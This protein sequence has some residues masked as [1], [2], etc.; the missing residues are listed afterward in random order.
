MS[1]EF[2]DRCLY[3]TDDGRRTSGSTDHRLR[4]AYVLVA[5][6]RIILRFASSGAWRTLRLTDDLL[7]EAF[8]RNLD[9][10]SDMSG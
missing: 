2:R 1:A 3:C 6:H 4:S 7:R 9:R 10:L 5:N 8:T